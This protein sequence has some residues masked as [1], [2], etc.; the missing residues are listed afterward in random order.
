MSG[1]DAV[2]GE[3]QY[4]DTVVI[5]PK[6][7]PNIYN[8]MKILQSKLGQYSFSDPVDRVLVVTTIDLAL[9]PSP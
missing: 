5:V 6:G 9:Q 2:S 1:G 8:S 3:K 7:N 4:L